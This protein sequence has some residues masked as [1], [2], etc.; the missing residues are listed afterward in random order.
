MTTISMTWMQIVA[1][2]LLFVS[3]MLI[4]QSIHYKLGKEWKFSII[5]YYWNALN[6]AYLL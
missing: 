5:L 2:S 4:A 6:T 3:V 1:N